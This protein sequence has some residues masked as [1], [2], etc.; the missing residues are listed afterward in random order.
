MF[1]VLLGKK[2]A[3]FLKELEEKT[4]SR[5]KSLFEVL[6]VNPWPAKEFDLTKIEG[7]DDCFRIRIGFVI[8]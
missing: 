8:T 5:I 6:E 2:A 3:K 4:Q 1:Q 7:T